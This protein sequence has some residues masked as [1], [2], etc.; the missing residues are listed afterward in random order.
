MSGYIPD[1]QDVLDS[2]RQEFPTL[3]GVFVDD[4]HKEALEVCMGAALAKV[5]LRLE[6]IVVEVRNYSEDGKPGPWR[7]VLMPVGRPEVVA[8]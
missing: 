3:E 4:K 6:V 7:A 2:V 8:S 1:D 5:R